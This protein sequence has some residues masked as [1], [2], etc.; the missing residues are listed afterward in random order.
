MQVQPCLL[1]SWAVTSVWG[2]ILVCLQN[3]FPHG[4]GYRM[5]AFN[6]DN[7]GNAV[8][9]IASL[10]ELFS[11]SQFSSQIITTP[12]LPSLSPNYPIMTINEYVAQINEAFVNIV[13]FQIPTP[14]SI[15]ESI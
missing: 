3:I 14:M 9:S 12:V 6:K 15:I 2:N 7:G 13:Y 8:S 11:L 4:D 1:D 5:K 10:A